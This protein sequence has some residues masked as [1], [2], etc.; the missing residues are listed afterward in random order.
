MT[1]IESVLSSADR[2]QRIT[3]TGSAGAIGRTVGPALRERGHF[4][5]GF[6][7]QDSLHLSE[8]VVGNLL[9]VS[10]VARCVAD[11]DTVIHL[12]ATPDVDDF[13]TKLVPNNIIGTYHLLE[14]SLAAGVKRVLL[15][16][17]FRVVGGSVKEGALA[18]ATT[19]PVPRDYYALTKVCAEQLGNMAAARGLQV[20]AARLGW[21]PR[22]A[23]EA[24]AM[25]QTRSRQAIY[26]S[27][28]DC[29][30]FFIRGVE[31]VWPV[32]TATAFEIVYVF[33]GDSECRYD[34]GPAKALLNY[35][36]KDVFPDG[37]DF[38]FT[39]C[40]DRAG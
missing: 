37:L 7:C 22:T 13:V 38:P 10:A 27:H 5:R 29:R 12:A 1:M 23:R 36:G 39:P 15:A 2:P 24:Q 17:T 31:S 28:N 11:A 9:D 33:S 20:I 30:N 34:P 35:Q 4:V 25:A 8:S 16:S 18:T 6:D 21:L 14:Q 19:P 32:Q 40:T 3:L 26:L